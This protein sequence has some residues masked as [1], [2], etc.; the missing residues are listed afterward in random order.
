[1]KRFLLKWRKKLISSS[2]KNSPDLSNV[3]NTDKMKQFNGDVDN[4]KMYDM[5]I[6]P[7]CENHGV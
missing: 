7:G 3:G 1:M 5:N 4:L 2:K 6:G